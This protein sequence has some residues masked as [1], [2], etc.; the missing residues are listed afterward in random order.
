MNDKDRKGEIVEISR[1]PK[2]IFV[3]NT[4]IANVK[5]VPNALHSIRRDIPLGI[6]VLNKTPSEANSHNETWLERQCE[7]V[8]FE[9]EKKEF[10][11]DGEFTC[12]VN[13]KW[14]VKWKSNWVSLYKFHVVVKSFGLNWI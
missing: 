6:H 14:K 13:F 4:L 5:S 7:R 1:N 11:E 3:D 2:L 8:Y 12:L 10:D 9:N